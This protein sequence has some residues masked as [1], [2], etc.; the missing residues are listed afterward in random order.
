MPNCPACNSRVVMPTRGNNILYLSSTPIGGG[1]D[2]LRPE[3][4]KIGM[5]FYEWSKACTLWHE[6]NKNENCLTASNFTLFDPER[7]YCLA[8]EHV[9]L[10]GSLA[11]KHF[12]GFNVSDVNGLDV[13]D[14]FAAHEEFPMLKSVTAMVNPT[15]AF[16]KGIGEVRFAMRNFANTVLSYQ[17]QGKIMGELY[18]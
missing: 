18:G 12:T 5:D 3:V 2:I 14:V 1:I 15:I 9:L 10:A 17:K 16:A 13:T 7:K 8:I 11:V 6:E 4:Y